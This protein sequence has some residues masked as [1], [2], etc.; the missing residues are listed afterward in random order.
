MLN[1][2]LLRPNGEENIVVP[3]VLLLPL[4]QSLAVIDQRMQRRH[5]N[6]ANLLDVMNRLPDNF[7]QL[8]QTHRLLHISHNTD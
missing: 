7:R 6:M 5:L 1:R 4:S 8:L 3:S 2:M